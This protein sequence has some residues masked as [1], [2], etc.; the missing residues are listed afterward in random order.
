MV[1]KYKKK[2]ISK[3]GSEAFQYS[4]ATVLSGNER[5]FPIALNIYFLN[6]YR[7]IYNW[8]FEKFI[9]PT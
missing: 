1:F 8:F 7:G 4:C 3:Y 5:N 2:N 6:S 9:T